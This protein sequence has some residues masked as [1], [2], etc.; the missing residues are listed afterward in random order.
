ME[1]NLQ[2]RYQVFY[3]SQ[4][5][6]HLYSR[7]ISSGL[8]KVDCCEYKFSICNCFSILKFD[9]QYVQ[10]CVR[11]F[12]EIRMLQFNLQ[13]EENFTKEHKNKL[14]NSGICYLIFTPRYDVQE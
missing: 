7:K 3:T 9:H 5:T 11:E 8:K 4:V 14:L 6:K 10:I 2:Q 12:N 13:A 1:G